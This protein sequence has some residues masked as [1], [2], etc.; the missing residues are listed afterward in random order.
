MIDTIKQLQ[1]E[2]TKK[3][4]VTHCFAPNTIEKIKKLKAV[5]GKSESR[6]L[7]HLINDLYDRLIL[8]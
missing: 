2:N 4:N 6:I 3:V 7:E 1:L 8:K 5:I